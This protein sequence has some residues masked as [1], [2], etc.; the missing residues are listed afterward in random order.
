VAIFLNSDAIIRL[1]GAVLME[2]NEECLLC[3]RSM[4]LKTLEQTKKTSPEL[5]VAA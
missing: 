5:L 3:R 4:T 2:Q 1:L